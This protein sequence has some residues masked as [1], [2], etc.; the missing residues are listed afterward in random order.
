M[1]YEFLGWFGL[2]IL[3]ISYIL[4]ISRWSKWFLIADALASFILTIYAIIIEDVPFIIVNGFITLMLIYKQ[5]KGG[6]E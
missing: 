1:F 5:V 4:L 3:L 2:S 6:I